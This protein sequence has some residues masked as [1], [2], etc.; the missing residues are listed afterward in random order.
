[1]PKPGQ[2]S[3]ELMMDPKE[4]PGLTQTFH[5][6]I[7]IEPFPSTQPHI[8]P[9][10]CHPLPL[11]ACQYPTFSNNEECQYLYFHTIQLNI[12]D[13]TPSLDKRNMPQFRISINTTPPG[14][15]T[16]EKWLY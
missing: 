9:I 5:A 15:Y 14:Q 10:V 13:L 7:N 3:E 12:A 11:W 6:T 16:L 4:E 2:T 1:V 8:T